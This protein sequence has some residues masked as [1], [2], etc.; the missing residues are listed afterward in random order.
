MFLC[1]L[2]RC[3]WSH[4]QIDALTGQQRVCREKASVVSCPNLY[5]TMIGIVGARN[6]NESASG[7]KNFPAC[8]IDHLEWFDHLLTQL[9]TFGGRFEF[10]H[11]PLK[12]ANRVRFHAVG[13]DVSGETER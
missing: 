9:T 1:N 3:S 8:L 4:I 7:V 10:A 12:L 11:A 5:V 2:E 6:P 13:P